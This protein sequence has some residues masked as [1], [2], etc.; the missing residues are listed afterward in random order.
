M[1]EQE[2]GYVKGGDV[3]LFITEG[4]IAPHR[5]RP[6]TMIQCH[7]EKCHGS[8]D[9]ILLSQREIFNIIH[10]KGQHPGGICW[11]HCPEKWII[12]GEIKLADEPILLKIETNQI[13]RLVHC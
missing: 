1:R 3:L 6:C 7:R 4:D 2:G 12:L 11:R 8:W 5:G 9:E 13:C 10:H